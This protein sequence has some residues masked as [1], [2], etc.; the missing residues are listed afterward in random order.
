MNIYIYT[1]ECPIKNNI[2]YIGKTKNLKERYHSHCTPNKRKGGKLYAYLKYIKN[3]NLKPILNIIDSTDDINWSWLEQ[4]WISQFKCW[5]FNLLN[6]TNGGEK[7]YHFKHSEET[8]KLISQKQ[9][10]K[11]LPK[12]WRNNISKG[13]KGKK[14]S[15]AHIINL[16][17]SHKNKSV[18][19]S[20]KSVYQIDKN[21]KI[22]NKFDSIT[23][24]LKF[25]NAN[26]DSGSISKVCN[27]KFRTAY[28]Y[29]WCYVEDYENLNINKFKRINQKYVFKIDPKT[30]KIIKKYKCI[31]DAE[32]DNNVSTGTISRICNQKRGSIKGYIFL[33][34]NDYNVDLIKNIKNTINM[35]YILEM[36]DLKTKEL[37]KTF[38]SIKHAQS[39]LNIKHISS[40]C[41]GN[42]N[43]AGGYFWKKQYI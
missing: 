13:K 8:K 17:K 21:F 4:Y 10:G 35:E 38:P 43:Q 36:I 7:Q 30:E 6:V 37:I 34:E 22:L 23:S 29:H 39:E 20:Y 32:K 12:E 18:E 15:N 1:L 42:R 33:F 28:G 11:K 2:F 9:L 31:T 3:N 40:V 14:F 16:S 19:H 27:G 24:A 26:I 41:S 25:I 5:G